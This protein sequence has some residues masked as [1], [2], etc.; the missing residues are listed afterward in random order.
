M[1]EAEKWFREIRHALKEENIIVP[2][3]VLT[4]MRRF[5][6]VASRKVR[7]GFL[8]AADIA[9]CHWL[10]P[11]LLWSQSDNEKMQ[12]MM[13]GLPRTLEQLRVGRK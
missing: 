8:A 4:C 6:E 10:V 12:E 9:V 3:V 1:T 7:G 5:M 11:A 13:A 2:D